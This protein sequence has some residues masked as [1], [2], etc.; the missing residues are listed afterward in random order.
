[1][2]LCAMDLINLTTDMYVDCTMMTPIDLYA[3]MHVTIEK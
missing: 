2:S 1:M 3:T